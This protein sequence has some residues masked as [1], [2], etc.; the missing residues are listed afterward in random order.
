ML[1]TMK[2]AAINFF[3][4][5]RFP[6]NATHEQKMSKLRFCSYRMIIGWLYPDLKRGQHRPLPACM[7]SEIQQRFPPTDD[8][9]LFADWRFSL[10]SE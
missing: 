2:M 7:Y 8:E 4:V 6:T 1:I 3:S 10:Y 9:E 5:D